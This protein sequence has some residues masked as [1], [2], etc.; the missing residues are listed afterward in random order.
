MGSQN[1]SQKLLL[2]LISHELLK[3]STRLREQIEEIGREADPWTMREKVGEVLESTFRLDRLIR[4]VVDASDMETG[5]IELNEESVNLSSLI[6]GRLSKR[7]RR[8]RNF[9]FLPEMPTKEISLTGDPQ[10]LSILVDDLLDAA[11]NLTPEGG[12]ILI[13]LALNNGNMELAMTNRG[14]RL[15]AAQTSSF[16]DWL[17]THFSE[18]KAIEGSSIS[19][20]RSNL[21]ANLMNGNLSLTSSEDEGVTFTVTIPGAKEKISDDK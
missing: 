10:R 6:S 4:D 13:R 16:I 12:I 7:F 19:L 11:V 9:R 15:P 5:S 17:S 20:Y 21:I 8:K 2:R 3:P 14:A 1:E 18:T